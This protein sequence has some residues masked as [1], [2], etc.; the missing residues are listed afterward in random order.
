MYTKF[1]IAGEIGRY[2]QLRMSKTNHALSNAM[3]AGSA[4]GEAYFFG[5]NT[6]MEGLAVSPII[7]PKEVADYQR[8][9]GLAWYAIL[10]YQIYWASDPDDTIIKYGSA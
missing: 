4:Y 5:N 3:G 1:P 7:V 9:R 10:G 2:S 6:V 8:S